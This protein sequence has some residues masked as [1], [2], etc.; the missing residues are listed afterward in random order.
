MNS[1]RNGILVVGEINVDLVLSGSSFPVPG[2]EVLAKDFTMALGSASAIAA[3]GLARLGDE[4]ELIGKVGA[5]LWGDFC[6]GELGRARV[7]VRRCVR[8]P[9]LKTG[10]TVSIST[11]Q[12]R[13]LVTYLGAIAA[14][15]PADLAQLSFEGLR[16]LHVSSYFLQTGLRPACRELFAR[17]HRAGL[18]TSLDPGFDPEER[19]GPD[20]IETL[21]EVDVFLP[22]EVELA[23]VGGAGDPGQALGQLDNGRTLVV[24]KLGA[25]GCMT[26]ER[27]TL[28]AV[29]GFPVKPVDTTGAGDSFNAGFLHA[30]LAGQPTQACLRYAAAC[31]AFSTLAVGGTSSQ[32]TAAQVEAFLAERG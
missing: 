26:L 6:L 20:L 7:D 17:A 5:D 1:A 13:A 12:D 32:A 22:N 14:L 24:A 25:K 8:D 23:A 31:G 28:I 2:T 18:T 19:W 30:W 3:A 16:H 11:A 21:T 29:A 27:G 9:G 15:G 4:V 10:V